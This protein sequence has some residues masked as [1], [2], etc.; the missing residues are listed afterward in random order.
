MLNDPTVERIEVRAY[1]IPT[2]CP[3]SDGTLEWNKTTIV[4]VEAFAGDKSGIGYTFADSA[5]AELIR[6]KLAE[7]VS[8]ASALD[9]Q[10]CWHKMIHS[11]RNLGRAGIASMAIS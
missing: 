6:H 8:G 1:E 2:D 3:E 4:V 7:L 5:T 10:A 9:V 11:I